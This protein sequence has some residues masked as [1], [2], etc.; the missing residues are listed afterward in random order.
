MNISDVIIHINEPLS[1]EMRLSL[2]DAMRKVD[3]L[4][5]RLMHTAACWLPMMWATLSGSSARY[6]ENRDPG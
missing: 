1:R 4:D 3:R 2:E 5:L 6:G